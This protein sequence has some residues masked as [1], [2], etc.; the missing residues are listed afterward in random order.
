[1]NPGGPEAG[2]GAASHRAAAELAALVRESVAADV[3]RDVLHLRLSGLGP[4]LVK[5]HHRRLLREAL[6]P[7]LSAARIRVFD[8]PNGDVVAVAP[9]PAPALEEAA[10]ALRRTLDR[11]AEA[12]LG[13]LRLPDAAAE[14]LSA[15]AGSLG[16]EP[17]V[18]QATEGGAALSAVGL[19]AAERDLAQADLDP[20]TR[21]AAVCELDLAGGAARPL[22][23]DLRPDWGALAAAVL[24]GTA[25]DAGSGL[26]RRL[27]RL[28]EA[29]LL[30]ELIRPAAGLRWQPVGLALSLATLEGPAFRR[31]DAA[32]PTGR[33]REVTVGFHAAEILAD[34]VRFAAARDALRARGY[35]LALDDAPVPL[36]GVLPPERLGLDVL[37]LEWD[38]A[39]PAAP[40]ATLA[41]LLAGPAQA[42]LVGVDRPAAV[43][44]GWEAGIRLFQ[45]PLVERRWAT[46]P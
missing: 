37:R 42:V 24:P 39:L 13:R 2:R 19:A 38:P 14:L 27:A 44:W 25:L 35:P 7:A 10:R 30:A 4:A 5:P 20:V 9:P 34:P 46:R 22:W 21:R 18:R 41:R 23:A 33:R 6:G 40:G 11:E 26:G 43:A 28:T 17:G 29:R 16:L 15:A 12:A 45:G 31:F 32:L 8:L 36:L 3:V 1:M